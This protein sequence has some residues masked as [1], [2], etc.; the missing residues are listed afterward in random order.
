MNKSTLIK[1]K[2]EF[3]NSPYIKELNLNKSVAFM[4]H[5]NDSIKRMQH[6]IKEQKSATHVNLKKMDDV[7]NGLN[8]LNALVASVM[9]NDLKL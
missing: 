7:M 1:A 2:A 4:M 5:V 3:E 6:T 9:S 8:D